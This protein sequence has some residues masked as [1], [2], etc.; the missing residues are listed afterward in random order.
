MA[1][2]ISKRLPKQKHDVLI[3]RLLSNSTGLDQTT[4]SIST[5]C[6]FAGQQGEKPRWM[7]FTASALR[8][9]GSLLLRQDS[10]I[11]SQSSTKVQFYK[12][13]TKSLTR[14]PIHYGWEQLGERSCGAVTLQILS[15]VTTGLTT[16]NDPLNPLNIHDA[17]PP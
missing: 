10:N 11:N 5:R 12:K 16:A 17:P 13:P 3:D 4:S 2:T 6:T 7:F 8:T 9:P 14:S 15:K 1:E